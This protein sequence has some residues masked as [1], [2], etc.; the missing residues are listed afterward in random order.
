MHMLL[1]VLTHDKKPR[2]Y[3]ELEIVDEMVREEEEIDT[4]EPEALGI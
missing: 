4:L 3:S 1:E 2:P